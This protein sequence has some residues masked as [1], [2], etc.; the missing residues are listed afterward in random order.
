M[1]YSLGFVLISGSNAVFFLA[2]T[3]LIILALQGVDLNKT[4]PLNY[5]NLVVSTLL[6]CVFLGEPLYFTDILGSLIILGYN[7]FNSLYPVKD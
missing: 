3:F 1:N 2:A 4:T 6:S 7:V 5:N